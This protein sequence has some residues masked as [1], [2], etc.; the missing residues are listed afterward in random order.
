MHNKVI[1]GE[2]IKYVVFQ[3]SA[4][5]SDKKDSLYSFI[6]EDIEMIQNN[7]NSFY[8]RFMQETKEL[9]AGIIP[10]RFVG[11]SMKLLRTT[12]NKLPF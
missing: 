10:E 4:Q 9:S 8:D 2:L 11:C 3:A 7:P 6:C 12:P 5:I 1:Y